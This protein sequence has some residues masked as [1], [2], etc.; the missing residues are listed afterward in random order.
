MESPALRV[1][2]PLLPENLGQNFDDF[3]M[4][5]VFGNFIEQ[6]I[7]GGA[8]M[9][10]QAGREGA[11]AKPRPL[12]VLITENSKIGVLMR[13]TARVP[14]DEK[15]DGDRCAPTF[16]ILGNFV[17]ALINPVCDAFF[18]DVLSNRLH[19]RLDRRL[20]MS[21]KLGQEFFLPPPFFLFSFLRIIFLF[22]VRSKDRIQTQFDVVLHIRLLRFG[23]TPL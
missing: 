14:A 12:G 7:S 4:D 22:L 17:F 2:T 5:E 20:L 10:A 3:F 1:K 6:C 13:W 21:I 9:T 19:G 23:I 11:L 8:G 16:D 18:F 15:T